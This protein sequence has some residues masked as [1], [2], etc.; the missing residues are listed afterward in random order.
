MLYN[1]INSLFKNCA[2]EAGFR[3]LLKYFAGRNAK[4]AIPAA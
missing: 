1:K 3:T 4:N 2:A